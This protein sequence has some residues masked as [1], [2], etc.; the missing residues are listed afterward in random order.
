[1]AL[2]GAGRIAGWAYNGKYLLEG[3]QDTLKGGISILTPL[4]ALKAAAWIPFRMVADA[5]KVGE[6]AGGKTG[7]RVAQVAAT[8]YVAGNG[9]RSL[10]QAYHGTLSGPWWAMPVTVPLKLVW[11]TAKA[12]VTIPLHFLQNNADG[13]AWL[14]R[15]IDSTIGLDR[16]RAPA[17]AHFNG[18]APQP[19]VRGKGTSPTIAL[20]D[21]ATA[22]H[23]GGSWSPKL[24]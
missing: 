17:L 2:E 4:R 6:S 10:S 1:M 22:P 20:D 19:A 24:Q 16:P 13:A 5:G 14:G 3:A 11:N 21:D 23:G 8:A 12:P 7:K 15:K 18:E 9:L